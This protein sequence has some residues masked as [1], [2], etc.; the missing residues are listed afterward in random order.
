MEMKSDIADM[1]KAM[2]EKSINEARIQTKLDD[3]E[4]RI[5]TN[6]ND[7]KKYHSGK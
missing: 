4:R 7:I 5:T 1:K 2:N 6:E 3:H